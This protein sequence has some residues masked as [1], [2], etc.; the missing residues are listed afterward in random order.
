MSRY[1]PQ[2][3]SW[4]SLR[5]HSIICGISSR[6]VRTV[7]GSYR[8]EGSY[9]VASNRFARYLFATRLALN[10]QTNRGDRCSPATVV[11]LKPSVYK[12]LL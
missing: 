3:G 4:T 10:R 12:S 9:R 8:V 1:E 11:S 5:S 2:S 6:K 7:Q